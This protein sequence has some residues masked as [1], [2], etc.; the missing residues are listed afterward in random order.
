MPMEY[1]LIFFIAF[2]AM[3]LI[4][5]GI[6]IGLSVKITRFNHRY[7]KEFANE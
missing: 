4:G 7:Q 1:L 6:L 2:S 5:V 3:G